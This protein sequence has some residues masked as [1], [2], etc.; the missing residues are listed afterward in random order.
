M[1]GPKDVDEA[2]PVSDTR[3]LAIYSTGQPAPIHFASMHLSA[4]GPFQIQ[5]ELGRGGMGVVYLAGDTPAQ[6]AG[7]DHRR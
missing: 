1:A 5:R 7:E 6:W 3:Q 2:N 4:I